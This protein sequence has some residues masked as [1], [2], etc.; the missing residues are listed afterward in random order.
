MRIISKQTLKGFWQKYQ[1]CEHPLKSWY[2]EIGKA[3]WQNHNDLKKQFKNASVVGTKRV[4]F[5][6]KGNKY[7]LAVDIEYQIK[8]VFVVWFGSHNEYDKININNI[9]YVKNN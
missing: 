8:L 6:I 9:S 7:R 1:E 5:N 2:E 3:Q 4:V